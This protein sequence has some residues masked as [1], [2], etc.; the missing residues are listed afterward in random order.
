M[1]PLIA[2]LLVGA[3][4]GVVRSILGY[5][6]DA[7]PE[8][9]FDWGKFLKSVLRASIAGS[10]IVYSTVPLENITTATYVTAFFVAVGADVLVKDAFEAVK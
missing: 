3:L 6:T 8:E 10:A 5:K 1:E 9:S 4:G 2:L 7:P